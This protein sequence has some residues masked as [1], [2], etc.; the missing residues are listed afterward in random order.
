MNKIE[1]LAIAL[2]I[3][4]TPIGCSEEYSQNL[5]ETVPSRITG[6][7]A[8]PGPGEVYLQ[9][10]NPDDPNLVYT[11][12]TYT[13][14]NGKEIDKLVPSENIDVKTG[15]ARDTVSGLLGTPTEF[16]VY[17]CTISGKN[18]GAEKI[19]ETPTTPAFLSLVSTIKVSQDFGGIQVSWKNDFYRA[20][21]I[22]IEFSAA[23]ND[24]LRGSVRVVAP[25]N[26]EDSAF[27]ALVSDDGSTLQGIPCLC[28][29]I[30]VDCQG[31]RSETKELT[32]T[33]LKV[34]KFDKSGWSF[35]GYQD[36]DGSATI[37][38]SSQEAGGEGA[39]PRGRVIAMIDNDPTT[40]W[41]T[42]WSAPGSS[43]P[44]WFILDMGK[45]VKISNIE[46]ARRMGDNRCQKH[47]QIFTCTDSEAQATSLPTEWNWVD[48]GD[49]SFNNESDDFNNYRLMSNPIARYIK[50][51][52]DENQGSS[53]FAMI[54][55]INVYGVE[56]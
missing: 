50:V 24:E 27:V 51:Y 9:W 42:R 39:S 18:Q 10:N 19:T 35:P 34:I 41:H 40:F 16:S 48:Q 33:P 26:S 31:H 53:S 54:R 56:L 30:A 47:L 38:Y 46:L 7:T 5:D 43:Y 49:F 8:T 20:T 11:R 29:L 12:I 21:D 3:G 55:E 13:D 44:H 1:I 37:G 22:L 25:G 32:V 2:F 17:T 23:E 52:F 28:R 4:F 6:L 36:D 45:D 15:I 14:E